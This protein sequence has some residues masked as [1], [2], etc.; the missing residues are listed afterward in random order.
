MEKKAETGACSTVL[1]VLNNKHSSRRSYAQGYCSWASQ[2]VTLWGAGLSA[3]P[4][5]VHLQEGGLTYSRYRQDWMTSE[6]VPIQ[7]PQCPLPQ[8]LHL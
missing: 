2:P 7:V 6:A 8:H 1:W 3:D 4:P 5:C